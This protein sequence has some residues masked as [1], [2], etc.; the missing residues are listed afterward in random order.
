MTHRTIHVGLALSAMLA[1][2]A[3]PLA[4]ARKPQTS[5]KPLARELYRFY[6]P[7]GGNLPGNPFLANGVA[8]GEAVP[9]YTAAGTGPTASNTLAPGGTPARYINYDLLAIT[10]PGFAPTAED[11]AAGVLP[12]GVS[13]TEAQGLSAM[14]AVRNN[15]EAAGLSLKDVIFMRIFVENVDGEARADYGGWNDAYR[16]YMANVDL[17]TGLVIPSFEPV[18]YPNP[19]RPARSNIEIGTMPVV[20]WLIEI[21]VVAAYPP[22][23]ECYPPFKCL[24]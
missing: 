4:E 10:S 16:K 5:G 22:Y 19:A 7:S 15:L 8:V 21:E 9:I 11:K 2:Q 14:Q 12:D 3:V 1:A 24:E 6:S 18:I 13:I 17:N 20:G 23:F